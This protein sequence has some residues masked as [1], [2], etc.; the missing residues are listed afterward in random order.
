MVQS[1]QNFERLFGIT[2]C[3]QHIALQSA[4]IEV[5]VVAAKNV[6]K[7]REGLVVFLVFVGK[8]GQPEPAGEIIRRALGHLTGD[9]SHF[10]GITHAPFELGIFQALN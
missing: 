1:F 10:A 3:Q 7:K 5:L 6:F 9:P 2:F 8:L 4:A